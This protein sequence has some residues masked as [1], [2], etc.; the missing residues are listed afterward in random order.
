V[1][2]SN[3]DIDWQSSKASPDESYTGRLPGT[4][5]A[6]NPSPFNTKACEGPFP[7][8][9][10]CQEKLDWL[11]GKSSEAHFFTVHLSRLV[12]HMDDM[13]RFSMLM[14]SMLTSI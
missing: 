10:Y 9:P 3:E 4:N 7:G 1:K 13:A 11:K 2:G 6:K 5:T 12:T 14:P 8:Y